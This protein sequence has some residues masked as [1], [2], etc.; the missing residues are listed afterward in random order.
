MHLSAP[1][2][3]VGFLTLL[4]GSLRRASVGAKCGGIDEYPLPLMFLPLPSVK[5]IPL[6][7]SDR[8]SRQADCGTSHWDGR[9]V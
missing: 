3:A 7:G 5:S 9:T 8:S 6:Y 4:P 1:V 2:L